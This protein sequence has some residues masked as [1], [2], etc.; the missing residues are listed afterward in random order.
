MI[1]AEIAK[2]SLMKS[3]HDGELINDDLVQII[4][5]LCKILNLKTLTNYAKAEKISYNGA[6]KRKMNFIEIDSIKFIIDND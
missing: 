6:K 5:H 3:I 2:D 1:K 4:E